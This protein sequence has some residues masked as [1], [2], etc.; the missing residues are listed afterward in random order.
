MNSLFKL[1]VKQLT[2]HAVLAEQKVKATDWFDMRYENRI[3]AEHAFDTLHAGIRLV[4]KVIE[5]AL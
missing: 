2:E 1:L 3:D 5:E 4:K